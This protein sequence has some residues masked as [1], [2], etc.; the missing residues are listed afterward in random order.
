MCKRNMEVLCI[1]CYSK[2]A[3]KLGGSMGL[4]AKAANLR[5]SLSWTI[6]G[7]VLAK[8]LFYWSSKKLG[9]K[10][11]GARDPAKLAID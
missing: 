5:L 2:Q 7:F 9:L 4:T 6:L 10:D 3:L 8:E 11:F 1:I